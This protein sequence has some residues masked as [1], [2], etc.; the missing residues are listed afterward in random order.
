VAYGPDNKTIAT[1]GADNQV[2]FWKPDD[3]GKQVRNLGGFGGPVFR[4]A[5][6]PDGKQLFACSADKSVRSF[7]PADGAT[8]RTFSGHNDWV[9]SLALSADGKTLASGSWDGE[10]RLWNVEDGKPLRTIL[11]A[12][13]L[14]PAAGPKSN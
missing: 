5:F 4:L 2:R 8:L 1:G 14:K 9:Y 13:G 7:N 3:E 11:A 6:L 12:P 10:V